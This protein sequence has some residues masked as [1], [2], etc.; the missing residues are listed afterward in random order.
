MSIFTIEEVDDATSDA[1]DI[2]AEFGTFKEGS[3]VL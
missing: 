2:T 1:N 3:Q